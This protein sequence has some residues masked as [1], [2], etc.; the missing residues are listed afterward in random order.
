MQWQFYKRFYPKLLF[1]D[2]MIWINFT[3]YYK[4]NFCQLVP[5]AKNIVN[6]FI[7]VLTFQ[8]F[9]LIKTWEN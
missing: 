9:L 3:Q 4:K 7:K 8:L 2:C 5:P 6:A 1:E